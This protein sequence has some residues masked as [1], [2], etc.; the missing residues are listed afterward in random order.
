MVK[1]AFPIC[2]VILVLCSLLR[3]EDQKAPGRVSPWL[4]LAGCE[5]Q[6]R[7]IWL[8]HFIGLI[9]LE[10]DCPCEGTGSSYPKSQLCLVSF[11]SKIFSFSG[12]KTGSCLAGIYSCFP[13]PPLNTGIKYFFPSIQEIFNAY[14]I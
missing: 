3:V 10:N 6:C 14:H 9:C 11:Q 7:V 1:S 2:L 13:P 5:L 4:G 8:D 12:C